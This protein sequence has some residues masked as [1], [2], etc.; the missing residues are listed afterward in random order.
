MLASKAGCSSSAGIADARLIASELPAGLS[1]RPA[2]CH[3]L[4]W[5][6]VQEWQHLEALV[7]IPDDKPSVQAESLIWTESVMWDNY[8]APLSLALHALR[9]VGR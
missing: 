2:F 3:F 7:S 6:Q 8:N 1:T 5:S 9:N 4:P